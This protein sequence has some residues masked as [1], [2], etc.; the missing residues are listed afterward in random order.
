MVAINDSTDSSF[1]KENPKIFKDEHELLRYIIPFKNWV[2]GRPDR[3]EYA[4]RNGAPK[5]LLNLFSLENLSMNE[6]YQVFVVLN[7]LMSEDQD[8]F[9]QF[10]RH[11]DLLSVMQ[12]ISKRDSTPYGMLNITL[13]VFNTML[14]FDKA[15]EYVTQLHSDS[16]INQMFDLY[17]L[18]LKEQ[19]SLDVLRISNLSSKIL[20]RLILYNSK[21]G[22]SPRFCS[23]LF[24]ITNRATQLRLYSRRRFWND[25]SILITNSLGTLNAY[26]KQ[27]V[28]SYKQREKTRLESNGHVSPRDM[29]LDE[30]E[31]V[32]EGNKDKVALFK[33]EIFGPNGDEYITQLFCL[34]RQFDPCIRLLSISCL[35]TLYKAGILSKNQTKEIQMI[36]TP[37]LI[38]LF[39]ES[40]EAKQIAP[41]ILA[42]IINENEVMQKTAVNAGFIDAAKYLLEYATKEEEN[43]IN[44][45][46]DELQS[47]VCFN[48]PA[49]KKEQK[50]LIL[51]SVLL[52]VAALTTSKDEY[53]KLIVDAKY[54]PVIINALKINSN[55]VKKAACECLLS[56]SRS[57]YILRTG[58]ADADVSEPL[59]KLLS[60]PDTRVKS[61]ATSAICNLVLKFS[62]LRE[63]FLTTNF[64]DT[65]I[66]NIST[67]DSSLRKKTVWVLRHVVFGDDETIQLEPL[68]KIGASKL[69]ELCNDEDLGVQEQMLQVL[70][71]FTC[72][73]EES[74]D[75]LL[76]MVPMELLAKILL[77]KL[78][79]KNPILIEP[80]IYILVHIA[81]S[82]GELRD[83]ILRQTKLLLLVKEIMLQEAQRLKPEQMSTNVSSPESDSEMDLQEDDFDREMRPPFDIYEEDT[84]E[85]N[86][87]ILLAG[88]WLCINILWPKQCTSPSQEDKERAS[89][90]QNLGFGECLQMLQNHSSPDVRERV[91]DALMYINVTD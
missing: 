26:L 5:L 21:V 53:R 52:A 44:F 31:N 35:V 28:K 72:Q 74:V 79:S 47:S 24:Q 87:E 43:E 14:S 49:T 46:S 66:S 37:I 81:A 91:K 90:L 77:E 30:I 59:I 78:E 8:P 19:P 61:T 13:K 32:F 9:V 11:E 16:I 23:A 69:V 7:S 68:K 29:D 22:D 67:K 45:S 89:I 40:R 4:I 6:K 88:I 54:L 33:S 65:L 70:R 2:I 51:E 15:A 58:L 82:D 42:I 56:L 36:V 38:R 71:N 12:M 34:V 75:F 83:S 39:F 17:T 48:L 57:V 1:F 63:K 73:K 10:L 27:H 60:D 86:S 80:S 76:K 3:K 62:P 85:P 20:H 18:P 25:C 64:I 50:N 55:S 41:R 84:Y